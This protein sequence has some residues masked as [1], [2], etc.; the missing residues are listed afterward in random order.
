[1]L[2]AL[3]LCKAIKELPGLIQNRFDLDAEFCALISDR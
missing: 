1:M 3:S 2:T